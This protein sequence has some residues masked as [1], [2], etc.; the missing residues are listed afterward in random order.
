MVRGADWQ[1]V[2][3]LLAQP[4][5]RPL[6]REVPLLSPE[7]EARLI[8]LYHGIEGITNKDHILRM[9]AFGGGSAAAN[10]LKRAVTEEFSGREQSPYGNAILYYVPQLC[11]VLARR[12]QDALEFLLAGSKVE[13][14]SGRTLWR[15][16]GRPASVRAVVGG[17]IKGLAL[18]EREGSQQLLDWYWAHPEEVGIFR[19]DGALDDCLDGAVVD[20]VYERGLVRTMGMEAAMDEVFSADL[21]VGMKRYQ[22]WLRTP[23]GEKWHRWS[24]EAQAA[25]SAKAARSR[26]NSAR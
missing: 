10:V 19:S 26:P 8:D 13:F 4:S 24:L 21:H 6:M 16:D 18:S 20:A 15:F 3:A 9:L 17:C 14:W 1:A 11:G 2:A 12:N 23:E 22:E 7:H 25:A 5:H